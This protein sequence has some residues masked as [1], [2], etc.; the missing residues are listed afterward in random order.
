MSEKCFQKITD[1]FVHYIESGNDLILGK[2]VYALNKRFYDKFLCDERIIRGVQQHGISY[3]IVY[4]VYVNFLDRFIESGT[5]PED[6]KSFVMMAFTMRCKESGNR[7]NLVEL[8]KFSEDQ[9]YEVFQK[10]LST[11][12]NEALAIYNAC[13]VR[14]KSNPRG[15]ASVY[16]SFIHLNFDAI[17][18]F[19]FE[20]KNWKLKIESINFF[21]LE[22]KIDFW[23]N[24]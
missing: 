18:N 15:K 12:K 23:F 7:M 5:I 3:G 22:L 10:V 24:F 8:G 13:R 1:D 17:F 2:E 4:N 6:D 14:R 16:E 11:D 9:L 19:Q 20:I 21:N